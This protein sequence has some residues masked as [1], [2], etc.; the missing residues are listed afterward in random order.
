MGSVQAEG[1][2]RRC[3]KGRLSRYER[4]DVA[5]VFWRRR[6]HHSEV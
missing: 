5:K 1:L 6:G 2:L 4:Q 3:K